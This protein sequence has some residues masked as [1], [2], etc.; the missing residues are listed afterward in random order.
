MT[1]YFKGVQ[2]RSYLSKFAFSNTFSK[3]NNVSSAKVS[4]TN[5]ID[6]IRSRFTRMM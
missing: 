1:L 6:N 4:V 5:V 3:I 2:V